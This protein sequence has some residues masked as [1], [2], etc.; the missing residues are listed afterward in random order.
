M[1]ETGFLAL[2]IAAKA[3]RSSAC[4]MSKEKT[5]KI[6]ISAFLASS[7]PLTRF[8]P[9]VSPLYPVV[10]SQLAKIRAVMKFNGLPQ[11]EMI[12]LT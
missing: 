3:S 2:I 8:N 4:A 12:V 6:S 10:P 11:V 5:R 1:K 7:G 9:W